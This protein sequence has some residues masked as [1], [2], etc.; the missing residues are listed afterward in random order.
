MINIS[1]QI[2]VTIELT[3]ELSLIFNH[4]GTPTDFLKN[5][6]N[7]VPE[8]ATLTAYRAICLQGVNSDKYVINKNKSEQF[9]W[10]QI[11]EPGRSWSKS[12]AGIKKFINLKYKNDYFVIVIRGTITA[13]DFLKIAIKIYDDASTLA[14]SVTEKYHKSDRH[15]KLL[16]NL[17]TL[18]LNLE[19][20]ADE[21]EI[22]SA[23]VLDWAVFETF[24]H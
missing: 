4:C 13:Y 17:K 2:D 15:K 7:I 16:S 22:I 1:K 5:H 18:S 23:E 12:M 8:L 20:Y 24:G 6:P 21:Q 3:S 10:E 11:S 14:G 19:T 9:D